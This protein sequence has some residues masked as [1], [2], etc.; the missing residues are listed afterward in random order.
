MS[1]NQQDT[2]AKVIGKINE[3]KSNIENLISQVKVA[4]VKNSINAMVKDAQKDFNK[5]VDKD[6]E[7]VKNK[8][9]KEKADI[10]KKAK[11][12]FD[13]HKKELNSL[14]AKVEKL[15]KANSKKKPVAKVAA[16]SA[17]KVKKIAK[18]ARKVVKN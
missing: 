10:E 5:L 9:I 13:N 15:I 4:E 1:E 16:T 3:L 6:L 18:K 2:K 7:V 11:K 17:Q 8:L 12:F 14:Q